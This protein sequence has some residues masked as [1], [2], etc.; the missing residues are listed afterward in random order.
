MELLGFFFLRF[1]KI[2]F[3]SSMINLQCSVNFRGTIKRFNNSVSWTESVLCRL[4]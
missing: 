4:S 1:L 3:N 2:Y